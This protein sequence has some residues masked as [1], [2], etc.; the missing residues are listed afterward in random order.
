MA[1]RARARGDPCVVQPSPVYVDGTDC[2]HLPKQSL[3]SR[4]GVICMQVGG[5]VVLVTVACAIPRPSST[6]HYSLHV[7]FRF[8]PNLG[9]DVNLG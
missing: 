8:T 5:M 3:L 2:R 9:Q 1:F 6:S 4:T 7:P